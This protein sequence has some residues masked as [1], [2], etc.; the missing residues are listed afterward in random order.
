MGFFD[1]LEDVVRENCNNV[2]EEQ[3]QQEKEDSKVLMESFEAFASR[4]REAQKD[5][6]SLSEMVY[7]EADEDD[8]GEFLGTV[9]VWSS[10]W[11]NDLNLYKEF[12][13]CEEDEEDDWK[14]GAEWFKDTAAIFDEMFENL[15]E[16]SR[17]KYEEISIRNITESFYK[18]T[19]YIFNNME[20]MEGENLWN[21]LMECIRSC[22]LKLM[23]VG[24]NLD[25][26]ILDAY[27]EIFDL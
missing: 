2:W 3:I 15:D 18:K 10:Y 12:F 23:T 17:E 14:L 8:L 4:I 21:K 5:F 9:Y 11:G 24:N 22:E 13:E 20:H 1:F 26:F 27:D 16:E 6:S 7:D 19:L 25:R